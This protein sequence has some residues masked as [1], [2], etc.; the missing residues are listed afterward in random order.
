[1][2]IAL[3]CLAFFKVSPTLAS[4]GNRVSLC[5]FA[6]HL[7]FWLHSKTLI[8][9]NSNESSCSHDSMNVYKMNS[10]IRIPQTGTRVCVSTFPP[11]WRLLGG[12][13]ASR[14]GRAER[15]ERVSGSPEPTSRERSGRRRDWRHWSTAGTRPRWCNTEAAACRTHPGEVETEGEKRV[16]TSWSVKQTLWSTNQHN[17]TLAEVLHPVNPL[18]PPSDL[19]LMTDD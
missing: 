7:S 10:S 5:M 18:V 15:P 3:F 17:N 9:C 4:R 13:T 19:F 16:F 8:S 12:R 6:Q 1:M 14:R 11:P 2:I